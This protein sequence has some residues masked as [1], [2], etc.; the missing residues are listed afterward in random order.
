[1]PR[2]KPLFS[3]Y[4]Q[5]VPPTPTQS[6]LYVIATPLLP[7]LIGK[8][9]E[10]RRSPIWA[11]DEDTLLGDNLLGEQI[12]LLINPVSS[13]DNLYRL[14]D[15]SLNGTEYE[16]VT[17]DGIDS[18]IPE[19]PAVPPL[20]PTPIIPALARLRDVSNHFV[21][22]SGI[23]TALLPEMTVEARLQAVIDAIN[24]GDTDI[25]SIV[26]TLIEIAGLLA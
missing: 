8:L 2:R 22:G 7:Y 21:T 11:D 23:D 1:M 16:V 6:A 13:V 12:M 14:L 24:G 18:I 4:N 15:T 17:T 10:M 26:T 20:Q 3:L 25:T 9:E 19:I 5:T